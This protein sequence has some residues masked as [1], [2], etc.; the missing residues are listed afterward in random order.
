MKSISVALMTVLLT[1][2]FFTFGEGGNDSIG[3]DGEDKLKDLCLSNGGKSSAFCECTANVIRDELTENE[4]QSLISGFELKSKLKATD[5]SS[6]ERQ[7]LLD[8][9]AKEKERVSFQKLQQVDSLVSETCFAGFSLRSFAHFKDANLENRFINSCTNNDLLFCKQELCC[10]CMYH[11]LQES[12]T[13]KEISMF[14]DY[15]ETTQ[16]DIQANTASKGNKQDMFI[17]YEFNL[18]NSEC[19]SCASPEELA[20]VILQFQKEMQEIKKLA[21]AAALNGA[22]AAGASQAKIDLAEEVM[23]GMDPSQWSWSDDVQLGDFLVR[24]N[25]I[26]GKD[27][28]S[29]EVLEDPGGPVSSLRYP[30]GM[31]FIKTFTLCTP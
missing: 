7:L 30:P 1:L 20:N 29:V 15:L 16:S 17:E 6:E 28:V 13:K 4:I 3:A 27:G 5:L 14:V 9:L 11:F 25:G 21:R 8:Q 18:I 24:I 23:N 12:Y 26:C 10:T 2:A 22:F 31:S 19:Y